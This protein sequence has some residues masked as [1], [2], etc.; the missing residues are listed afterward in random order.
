MTKHTYVHANVFKSDS[1][2]VILPDRLGR[3]VGRLGR[4]TV[5]D[6]NRHGRLIAINPTT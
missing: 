1:L 5:I 2:L 6:P 4:L 3:L